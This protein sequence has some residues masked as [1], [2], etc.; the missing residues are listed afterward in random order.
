MDPLN[1]P[2]AAS[3][4]AF[5]PSTETPSESSIGSVQTTESEGPI[6]DV[7]TTHSDLSDC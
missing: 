4:S 7:D 5:P 2:G 1:T 3:G 6:G